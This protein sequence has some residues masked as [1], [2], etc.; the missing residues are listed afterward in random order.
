MSGGRVPWNL[1]KIVP[2]ARRNQNGTGCL[3]CFSW[4]IGNRPN[5]TR[6]D[7]QCVK[8]YEARAIQTQSPK[9]VM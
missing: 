9:C 3:H 7:P 6:E 5:F 2:D 8:R 1:R 4:I